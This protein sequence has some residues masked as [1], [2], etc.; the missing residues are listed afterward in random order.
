MG[1]FSIWH[2][3]ILLFFVAVP[4]CIGLVVWLILRAV[5][6]P[7][8]VPES[9]SPPAFPAATDSSAEARLLELASLRSK[10]LI[11]DAEFEQ[12]RAAILGRVQ[13]VA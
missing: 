6:K 11:T 10:G 2:W 5:K 13:G 3:I 9:V 8:P 12:G 4:A 1:S 7:A